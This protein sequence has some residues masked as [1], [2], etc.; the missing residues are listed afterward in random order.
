[1]KKLYPTLIILILIAC[2][3]SKE[4]HYLKHGENY[5]RLKI[6]QH[7]F[8]SS[9]RYMSGEFDENAVNYFFSEIARP[10]S[11]KF[12]SKPVEKISTEGNYSLENKTLVFLLSTNSKEVT[13]LIGSFASNE[14]TLKTIASITRRE[15]IAEAKK[16]QLGNKQL[17]KKAE[18]LESLGKEYLNMIENSSVDQAHSILLS[19]INHIAYLRGSN[20]RFEDLSQ[21]QK[22][23]IDEY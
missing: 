19:Y 22:W 5:Y 13:D 1:M 2:Q 14:Q 8:L 4:L 16:L 18:D 7:A 9:S 3:S 15:F 23:V 12:S 10:D 6:N 20:K 11:S 21:A 17:D